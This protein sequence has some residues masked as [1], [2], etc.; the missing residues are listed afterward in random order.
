MVF[1]IIYKSAQQGELLLVEGGF[2]RWHIRRDGQL[3]I[4]EIISTKPG[5]GSKILEILK[6]KPV[7]SIFAKCPVHLKSNEWYPRQGFELEATVTTK[8]GDKLNHWRLIL[9]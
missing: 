8:S 5:A 3:T 2:C 9:S 1:E 7:N 4:Y 6:K